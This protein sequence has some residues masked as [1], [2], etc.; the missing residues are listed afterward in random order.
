ME[1]RDDEY[2]LQHDQGQGWGLWFIPVTFILVFPGSDAW[3]ECRNNCFL[4]VYEDVAPSG[5]RNRL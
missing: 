2:Q 4:N 1:K 5:T 3:L